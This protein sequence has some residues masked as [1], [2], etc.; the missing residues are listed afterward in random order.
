MMNE[1]ILVTYASR[2]GSTAEAAEAIA[3]SLTQSGAQIDLL[4]MQA[5]KNLS[6][7]RAV[8]I[9]SAI[10]KSKWLP[11]AT[12]FIQVHRTELA[13]KP[14]AIFTV[15]ITLA[16]SNGEQYR[17]A[18]VAWTAPVRAQLH[19]VSEGLFAGKLDFQKLPLT[20]DSLLFRLAVVF[21]VIP[22]G[23]RRDW[24]AIHTWA[25]SLKPL[26]PQ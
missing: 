15:C 14:V 4:P 5:V 16:I 19:P 18:V 22:K 13:Q 23:D 24:T 21:R 9:G 2:T 11:E 1:K 10:R 20:L 25:Q 7:Y 17:Q 26:L 12:Q 6:P 8:V 3:K